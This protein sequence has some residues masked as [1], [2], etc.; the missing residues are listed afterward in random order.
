MFKILYLNIFLNNH[1]AHLL[2]VQNVFTF[3]AS[4]LAN[5]LPRSKPQVSRDLLVTSTGNGG[6]VATALDYDHGN[7]CQLRTGEVK[8]S[9]LPSWSISHLRHYA[10]DRTPL[11]Y[12][13]HAVVDAKT[14]HRE[15]CLSRIRLERQQ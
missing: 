4:R 11:H 10:E 6:A 9:Y 3:S 15:T 8:R 5:A 2:G 14:S 12:R 13:K 1:T 7:R